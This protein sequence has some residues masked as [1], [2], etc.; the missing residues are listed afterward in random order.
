[1]P[2]TLEKPAVKK[3][4]LKKGLKIHVYEDPS[5]TDKEEGVAVL[6]RHEGNPF[7]SRSFYPQGID[8]PERVLRLWSVKFPGV[9]EPL[10]DR[11]VS[12]DDLVLE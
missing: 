4:S 2:A 6:N 5:T 7:T 3:P 11:W 12:A 8:G 9:G 10:V 1:M